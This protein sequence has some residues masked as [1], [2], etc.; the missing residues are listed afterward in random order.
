MPDQLPESIKAKRLKK[1][2]EVV[3]DIA[4]KKK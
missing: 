2:I 3:N 4:G 1:L